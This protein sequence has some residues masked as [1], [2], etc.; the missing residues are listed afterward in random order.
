LFGKS[1]GNSSS[2]NSFF[3]LLNSGVYRRFYCASLM[4]LLYKATALYICVIKIKGMKNR[5]T[6]NRTSEGRIAAGLILVAAGAVLLMR[7]TGFPLPGWLF[8]W[9]MILIVMGIYTAIKSGFSNNGWIV[10]TGVGGFFLV[11]RFIPALKLSPYFWPA[12]IITLG[13]LFILRPRRQNENRYNPDVTGAGV[14]AVAADHQQSNFG[15]TADAN[16]IL[17]VSSVFSGVKKNIVSK[18]FQGGK[19]SCVFGGAEIDLTQADIQDS[20]ELR[21]EVVFGGVELVVPAHWKVFNEIDGVFHG[22]DDERRYQP[23]VNTGPEKI[24]ILKGSV[25][26]GGVEI[27]SY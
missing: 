6:R 4:P 20:A 21:F 15:Y 5:L 8:T 11:D 27:K 2:T 12:I 3:Y 13:L 25:I 17:Q 10:L 1:S 26:F 14:T 19:I 24:L 16:D 23:A 22:V 18:N 9:P 7:N